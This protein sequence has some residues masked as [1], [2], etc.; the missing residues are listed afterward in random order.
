M[1]RGPPRRQPLSVDPVSITNGRAAQKA[2]QSKLT[3]D[4]KTS[5][6]EDFTR[7]MD[8]RARS[9][10]PL[11]HQ[12][13]LNPD[14]DIGDSEPDSIESI[15]ARVIAENLSSNIEKAL[16]SDRTR[17]ISEIRE[18]RREAITLYGD[19]FSSLS[20][21]SQHRIKCDPGYTDF[22]TTCNVRMLWKSIIKSHAAGSDS[23]NTTAPRLVE[24]ELE[25]IRQTQDQ[26]ALE[27]YMIFNAKAAAVDN[28]WRAKLA[29]R[30]EAVYQIALDNL[31]IPDPLRTAALRQAAAT[32]LAAEKIYLARKR[33]DDLQA[34]LTST[35]RTAAELAELFISKLDH[36]RFGDLYLSLVNDETLGKSSMPRTVN[37]AL[38][39]AS[40]WKITPSRNGFSSATVLTALA[41]DIRPEKKVKAPRPPRSSITLVAAATAKKTSETCY[42]CGKPG[43]RQLE[44]KAKARGVPKVAPKTLTS[45]PKLNCTTCLRDGHTADQCYAK[46]RRDGHNKTLVTAMAD[47]D[48]ETDDKSRFF[49]LAATSYTTYPDTSISY[50][51]LDTG[52]PEH[53]VILDTG[54]VG[55]II[56][57]LSL[58]TN[59][60]TGPNTRVVGIN[61]AGITLNQYGTAGHWGRALYNPTGLANVVSMN[62][63]GPDDRVAYNLLPSPHFAVQWADGTKQIFTKQT[64]P[65]LRGLYCLDTRYPGRAV[66]DTHTPALASTT[67][68]VT[69]MAGVGTPNL[70]QDTA[71]I[72][73]PFTSSEKQL[74]YTKREVAQ[75]AVAREYM[76]RML[77][78]P[79]E[80]AL[81][82]RKGTYLNTPFVAQDVERSVSIWGTPLEKLKGSTTVQQAPKSQHV[83]PTHIPQ[84]LRT[85]PESYGDVLYICGVPFLL[86][87]I[88]P[89]GMCIT[90]FLKDQKADTL[91]KHIATALLD[92]RARGI[93]VHQM[94][95][96]SAAG[97]VAAQEHV[98][99][100][101]IRISEV[102]AGVH[103]SK[104]E[105]DI[106]TLKEAMR[107]VITGTL[108]PHHIDQLILTWLV[109]AC[110]LMLNCRRSSTLADGTPPIEY[111]INRKVD[112]K[113]D[114]KTRLLTYAQVT[115]PAKTPSDKKKVTVPRTK[116]MIILCP[117][118]NLAGSVFALNLMTWK[119]V[120]RI[121]FTQLPMPDE[122]ITHIND[123][124]AS[125]GRRVC[126]GDGTTIATG[127]S[128]PDV[129]EYEDPNITPDSDPSEEEQSVSTPDDA[130]AP[131]NPPKYPL[132]TD[133]Q[134]DQGLRFGED[135]GRGSFSEG[136]QEIHLPTEDGA[137]Q[138]DVSDTPALAPPEPDIH[139]TLA[140]TL[141]YK[142]GV[143]QLGEI[144]SKAAANSEMAQLV[145]KNVFSPVLLSS[146]TPEER[147][148]LIPSSMNLK[149]KFDAA[150]VFEKVKA[151]LVAGGHRQHRGSYLEEETAAPTCTMSSIFMLAALAS[152]A[153]EY[154]M[155]IDVPGA[156]LNATPAKTIYMRL[157]RDM[158]ALYVE[159][160]PSA[161]HMVHTDGCITVRL[162]K[163][164]YGCVESAMLWYH[165][166]RDFLC[167]IGFEHCP[168]D[169]CM[170]KR[171]VG[172]HM[173]RMVVYVDD[174]L[175][176][177]QTKSVLDKLKEKFREKYGAVTVKE[178]TSQSYLGMLFDFSEVGALRVTMPKATT[179]LLRD[180]HKGG[181][182]LTPAVSNL[183][184]PG[185]SP[186]LGKDDKATMYSIT[187]KLLHIAKRARPDL[188]PATQYLTTRVSAPNEDDMKKADRVLQYLAGTTELGICLKTDPG[189]ISIKAF[190]DASYGAHNDG[191]SQTGCVITLGSGPVY[192]SSSKQKLNTKSSCESEFVALSDKI[193]QVIWSREVLAWLTGQ[194]SPPPAKVYEDNMAV[195]HLV[196][197]GRPA[198]EKSR[199]IDIRR[200]FVT[201]RVRTGDISIEHLQTDHMV[202]D[203]MT[204]PLQGT[205]FVDMRNMLLNWVAV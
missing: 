101:H 152:R 2:D 1:R 182:A 32:E 57:S 7:A 104:A 72:V 137:P 44:C 83:E 200:F 145:D 71:G 79:R 58:L 68:T 131:I 205:K 70:S 31:P 60:H 78:T 49:A 21:S 149:A 99:H 106:R 28:V 194:E 111:W 187:F 46:T 13:I 163:A 191:R 87:C 47:L 95:T 4:G 35:A 55:N 139:T 108:I 39:V 186:P 74:Q 26:S 148:G 159:L 103:V 196:K 23:S 198:S 15:S 173:V 172:E 130:L 94:Y 73:P 138:T 12:L 64:C 147:K 134:Y 190:I 184:E 110:A 81:A 102:G 128:P 113:L 175:V 53:M 164:L 33:Q 132:S 133:D 204:K 124:I 195:I 51:A 10:Y 16:L 160:V 56:K 77:I 171:G 98:A 38:T 76:S 75:A 116:G 167:S 199:H 183:Y 69:S 192:V 30:I 129:T 203:F 127:D 42:W 67:N 29:R 20:P 126:G 181:T 120:S 14:A 115:E 34:A 170:F 22:H 112:L 150:G 97:L 165:H 123:H 156:Y 37:D 6:I 17:R 65:R 66:A 180:H 41:D 176:S 19:L 40:R 18:I 62:S 86:M 84:E 50:A 201:D 59:L 11:N 179:E 125:S 80:L 25:K 161:T 158:T 162:L 105:R 92:C 5:N 8:L 100:L 189:P 118:M 82:V 63:I 153:G 169:P 54:S 3:W 166:L 114:F 142:E 52:I 121:H 117:C 90:Y 136:L 36:H 178:G 24:E 193:S 48:R 185:D 140:S 143:I 141:K 154:V 146:L 91:G 151:R 85:S 27:F 45:Q 43:H 174:L 202:A 107:A 89:I 177:C 93:D 168:H 122:V 96:D 109:K 197:R 135:D 157:D 144:P 188:L 119:V 88:E 155:G 61:G 9:G